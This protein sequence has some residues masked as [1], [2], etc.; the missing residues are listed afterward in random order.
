M[1]RK[2]LFIILL[3]LL[4]ATVVY[5][6]DFIDRLTHP[7]AIG[8]NF[9]G[10]R[11][12]RA[13]YGSPGE[14]LGPGAEL[15]IQYN[16]NPKL[17]MNIGTGIITVTDEIFAGDSKITLFPAIRLNLGYNIF[18]SGNLSSYL[19]AG[20]LGFSAKYSYKGTSIGDSEF[21]S[22]ISGGLGLNYKLN[23]K[24]SLNVSGSGNYAFTYEPDDI[25]NQ[26]KPLFWIAK[27][28][29]N[30]SLNS[31]R[32]KRNNKDDIEYPFTGEELAVDDLFNLDDDN[33]YS[34]SSFSSGRDETISEDDALSLLFQAAED[35]GQGDVLD[36]L[37]ATESQRNEYA[38]NDVQY[39]GGD[40]ENISS[41]V[42]NLREKLNQRD[43]IIAELRNKVNNN[44]KAIL[45]VSKHFSGNYSQN[46]TLNNGSYSS[47]SDDD[48]VLSYKNALQLFYSKDYNEAINIFRRLINSN[49]NHK[50]SSNCQYWV[51]ESF[52]ALGDFRNAINAFNAVKDYSFSYKYDD[53]LIMTGIISLKIGDTNSA[54]NN[55][56]KLVQNYPDSEYAPKAMRFLAQ[57]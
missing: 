48:F 20:L 28:G 54:R 5:S 14:G 45:E 10:C 57:L 35:E 2:K 29:I 11:Q 3:V 19:N 16:I 15:F 8:G 50:L 31:T 13:S 7:D 21:H 46:S 41:I 1:K 34:G 47:I 39:S 33:E 25:T 36:E 55:F 4:M 30:Y 23:D 51:G 37:F 53:A 40:N 24:L 18:E 49:S 56:Q 38:D 17:F 9:I 12:D 27:M 44:E 6:Q 52:N 32:Q 26:S 43:R 22:A 42:N